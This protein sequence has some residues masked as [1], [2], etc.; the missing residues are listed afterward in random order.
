MQVSF[1]PHILRVLIYFQAHDVATILRSMKVTPLVSS[2][3]V[4]C[5]QSKIEQP[6]YVVVGMASQPFLA[7]IDLIF[8]EVESGTFSSEQGQPFSLEHWVDVCVHSFAGSRTLMLKQCQLDPLKCSAAVVG[9]EQVCDVELDKRTVIRPI[10]SERPATNFKALWSLV[11]GPRSDKL[12]GN[13]NVNNAPYL[14]M[15]GFL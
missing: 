9:E 7:K 3:V 13:L 12:E 8:N 14:G 4:E 15:F 10:S 6:P 5:H 2:D 1:L 11:G